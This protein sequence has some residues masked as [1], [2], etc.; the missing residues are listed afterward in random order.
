M[1]RFSNGRHPP[2]AVVGCIRQDHSQFIKLELAACAHN[3]RQ[4]M[5]AGLHGDNRN[6]RGMPECHVPHRSG[7]M[8]RR[9]RSYSEWSWLSS[10]P[11]RRSRAPR[12]T[13]PYCTSASTNYAPAPRCGP[14]G[15]EHLFIMGETH[16]LVHIGAYHR[17]LWPADTKP[18]QARRGRHAFTLT[19]FHG[20][21]GR[22]ARTVSAQLLSTARNV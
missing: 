10:A 19:E 1:R 16:R 6:Q 15:A 21:L 12:M 20:P 9:A 14:A 2:A 17:A 3:H 8:K 5:T 4:I 18:R 7:R 22:A 11:P 13:S